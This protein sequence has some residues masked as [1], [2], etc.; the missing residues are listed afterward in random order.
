[1]HQEYRPV[2]PLRRPAR[3]V[4]YA[5]V[6][7]PGLDG[8]DKS[9]PTGMAEQDDMRDVAGQ[10]TLLMPSQPITPPFSFKSIPDTGDDPDLDDVSVQ[11]TAR[12]MQLSGMVRAMRPPRAPVAGRDKQPISQSGIE[13]VVEEYW[14][15]GIQQTGPLPVINLYGSEPFGRSAPFVAVPATPPLPIQ[16]PPLWKTLL[17]KPAIKIALGLLVGVA[18]LLLVAQFVNV[19]LTLQ[20]LRQN[21]ATPRGIGLA[22]LSG[23]AF[24]TAFALRGM[25]WRLFLNPICKLSPLRVMQIFLV[26]TFLNFLLPIRGGEVAKALILKRTAN[27]PVS[28]SLPTIAMDK[29]LDLMPALCIIALVPFL[30]MTLD[31]QIWIIL[32]LVGGLLVGMALFVG[33]A[34]WKRDLAIALLHR[35]IAILP[36][37]IGGKI[38]GFATGF[39]DSL[40][41]GASRPKIFLPAILLTAV[42][43]FFEGLFA[44]LA[45]WTIGL[46]ISFGVAIFGYT[47]YN[48]FYILPT[49]PGQVGS[50]EAV[51]L[52]VFAGLLGL[53]A[54][55]VTAMF[56]F[57]HPW[58]AL[59][60]TVIGM[61]SLSALGLT[62]SGALKGQPESAA[63]ANSPRLSSEQPAPVV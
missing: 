30:G 39:V 63:R 1:M 49:P 13:G 44:M 35:G 8:R 23:V 31:I 45:F 62:I 33:L 32:I 41:M 10:P 46:Q 36:K 53:P 42:A 50:N 4:K 17:G 28:Q 22:L 58:A 26:G 60:M 21:L 7:P 9:A 16:S 25:R 29:A 59:M 48:M 18:L 57:S 38:E 15:N 2:S 55:K 54:D 27:V 52:L 47:L 51:G 20:V 5:S 14:P 61:T 11:S 43:V 40:L 12:L 6:E 3:L 24:L 34:A 37:F 19:P 56:L